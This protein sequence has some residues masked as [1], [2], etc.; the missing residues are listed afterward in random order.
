MKKVRYYWV[1][2]TLFLLPLLWT[3]TAVSKMSDYRQFELEMH[4]QML[5]P[6]FQELLVYLLPPFELCLAALF[7]LPTLQVLT[8]Q[9]SLVLLSVFTAYV[10]LA[11]S[12]ISGHRPCSCGGILESMGWSAHLLFNLFFL[13]LT[14]TTLYIIKRKDSTRQQ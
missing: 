11:L 8:L 2:C 1:Q 10:G 12:G 4:E 6:F 5:Y 7:M 13:F 9:L 3:Y 14:A